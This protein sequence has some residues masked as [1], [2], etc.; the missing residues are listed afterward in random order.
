MAQRA[1]EDRVPKACPRG[2]PPAHS[3]PHAIRPRTTPPAHNP[4][5]HYPPDKL[6]LAVFQKGKC[7]CHTVSDRTLR[8]RLPRGR[9]QAH[10]SGAAVHV[11]CAVRTLLRQRLARGQMQAHVSGAAVHVR[12]HVHRK[13]GGVGYRGGGFRLG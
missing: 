11:T 12:V 3:I 9:M 4:P 1:I 8:Q 6:A 5:A 7:M 13:R 10:V 2:L